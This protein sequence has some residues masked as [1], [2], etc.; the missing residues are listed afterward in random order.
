MREMKIMMLYQSFIETILK[1]GYTAEMQAKVTS[2]FEFE[3]PDSKRTPWN[4]T[5]RTQLKKFFKALKPLVQIPVHFFEEPVIM[6]HGTLLNPDDVFKNGI[7]RDKR[8]ITI[9][10]S[11]YLAKEKSAREEYTYAHGRYSYPDPDPKTSLKAF[12]LGYDPPQ[13]ANVKRVNGLSTKN[14]FCFIRE[15]RPS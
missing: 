13:L 5:S 3:F 11:E 9:E 8:R 15:P 12:T 10:Q 4:A 7:Q 14:L 6:F 2:F 1:K